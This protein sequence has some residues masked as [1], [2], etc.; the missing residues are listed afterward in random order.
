MTAHHD[1]PGHAGHSHPIQTAV[2]ILVGTVA[3][4]IAIIMLATLAVGSYGSRDLKGH[5]SMSPEAI[6]KRIAPVAKVSVDPNA[7]A[8]SPAPAVG[9]VPAPA[10]AAPPPGAAPAKMAAAGASAGG[11]KSTYDTACAM[12]H[13]AGVA[14]APKL[15]DKGAWAPR[16]AQG[17]PAMHAAAIK[18]K[19]AMPPKG[20]S[21]AP[22]ADIRA[23]V[24][25]MVGV[26]K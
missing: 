3:V 5:P 18:G 23:A 17:M 6:A 24:D 22:D 19:G 16:L 13:A 15:G 2:L 8:P 9:A 25:Y 4:I 14:G 11:G 1:R 21:A 26:S 7:P 20:G 12:C 10:P